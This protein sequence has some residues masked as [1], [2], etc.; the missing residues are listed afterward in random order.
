MKQR[1]KMREGSTNVFLLAA[2][3]LVVLMLMIETAPSVMVHEGVAVEVPHAETTEQHTEDNITIALSPDQKIAVNDQEKTKEGRAWDLPAV[4]NVVE[5]KMKE[6]PFFLIVI[7]A[8]RNTKHEWVLDLLSTVKSAGARRIA[9]ATK[10][11]QTKGKE[12]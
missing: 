9:I 1:R 2:V 3:A 6:D 8:D 12:G 4:R 7:R 10:K 11:Q 5:Q